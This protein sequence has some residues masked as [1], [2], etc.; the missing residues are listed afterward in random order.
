MGPLV[1]QEAD[2]KVPVFIRAVAVC[3]SLAGQSDQLIRQ[4]LRRYGRY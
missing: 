2:E 3:A 1:I 4:R